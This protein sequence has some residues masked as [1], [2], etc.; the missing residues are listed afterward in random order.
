MGARP[1]RLLLP[2]RPRELAA[3]LRFGDAGFFARFDVGAEPGLFEGD[4]TDPTPRRALASS[5]QAVANL[6]AAMCCAACLS[7]DLSQATR[8]ASACS[9]A[10][11]S[12]R[13]CRTAPSSVRRAPGLACAAWR[14]LPTRRPD[15]PR[16]G[17]MGPFSNG[18]GF[19]RGLAM[20]V[21]TSPDSAVAPSPS[22]ALRA[23]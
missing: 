11:D 18:D 1:V 21:G 17:A 2:E 20:R 4:L 22:T 14:A 16:D 6:S 23:C 7:W 10:S 13:E 19:D 5:A 12:L 8:F 3:D 9:L 15:L